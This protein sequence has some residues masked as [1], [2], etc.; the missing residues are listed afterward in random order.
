MA[1]YNTG[2][3]R[4][5]FEAGSTFTITD[6]TDTYTLLAMRPGSLKWTPGGYEAIPWKDRGVLKTPLEGD[7]MPTELEFEGFFTGVFTL[8]GAGA[9]LYAVLKQRDTSTGNKKLFSVVAKIYDG[10]GVATF[11][12]IT[13]AYC[14]LPENGLSFEHGEKDDFIKVKLIDNEPFPAGATG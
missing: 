11:D 9:D 4:K 7:E 6:S 14:Y 12:T 13:F 1:A 10:K 3:V 8:A 5:R 2:T